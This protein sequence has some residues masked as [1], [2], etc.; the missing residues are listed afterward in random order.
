MPTYLKNKYLP[1]HIQ[2][3]LGF[4]NTAEI[5]GPKSNETILKWAKDIGIGDIYTNDDIAWCGLFFATCMKLA[6]R[7]VPVPKDKYDYLRALKYKTLWQA[8]Q[9]STEGLGD[10]LIFQREGGGHIGFYVA[11]SPTT[12]SV[13]G[14]NQGNRVSIVEIAKSRCVAIR[15]PLYANYKPEKILLKKA[16]STSKNEA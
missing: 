4:M 3:A 11:E 5:T 15:R 14:G 1:R 12:Y 2:A 8:V 13:L 7:P 16:G 9:P 10:I 6:D